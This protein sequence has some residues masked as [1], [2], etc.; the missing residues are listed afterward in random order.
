MTKS[1]RPLPAFALTAA[2]LLL[3]LSLSP[4]SRGQARAVD[5]PYHGL[6]VCIDPGHG[7]A[8]PGAVNG[9]LIEKDINLD[10][11]LYL[12]ASIEARGATVVM[13]RAVDETKSIRQRY[14]FCNDQ[15]AH[16]LISNHTNSVANET[17]D[18]SMTIYFHQD[19]KRLA[20]FLQDAMYGELSPAPIAAGQSFTNWPLRKDALGVLLKTDMPAAV[21]EP[22]LMSHP[23]EAEQLTGTIAECLA[24]TSTFCRRVQIAESILAGLDAYMADG[25]PGTGGNGAGEGGP[26]C[27][28]NTRAKACR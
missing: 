14:T 27:S 7:G 18:G 26:D 9:A 24:G 8:E 25:G 4:W 17:I 22:V 3:A 11:G 5:D 2:M 1:T 13:T 6:I 12:Q 28:T 10:I 16:L 20:G 21:V 19:D 15:N 23:W